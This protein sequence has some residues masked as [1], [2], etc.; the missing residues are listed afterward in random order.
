MKI[1]TFNQ[2]LLQKRV[3]TA[4]AYLSSLHAAVAVVCVCRLECVG[5]AAVLLFAQEGGQGHTQEAQTTLVR[6][7]AKHITLYQ[8]NNN[9]AN[10][11][12]V[13]GSGRCA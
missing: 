5:C 10:A 12:Y 1:G 6:D 7:S 3:P 13:S 4:S 9:L 8:L 2:R 11:L